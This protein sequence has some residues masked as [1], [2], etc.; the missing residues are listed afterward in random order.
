MILEMLKKIYMM[1]PPSLKNFITSL[2]GFKLYKERYNEYYNMCFEHYSKQ[3]YENYEKE[4]ELQFK[5][6][7]LFIQKA[8][9]DSSFYNDLYANINLN[10][11]KSMEDIKLL[12]IVTKESLRKNID[13][14]RTIKKSEGVVSFT[15]GTTGTSLEVVFTKQDF[16]ERMAYLDAFKYK[17][18]INSG[19]K[20]ATFS[21][22]EIV[23]SK[24]VKKGVYWCYNYIYKQRMYSTFH[25]KDETIPSYLSDLNNFKPVIINGFVSAIY[26]I[27]KYIN[28]NGVA[29][30][31]TPQAIFTTSEA[32]LPHHK[33]VIEKAFKAKVYN[34]YASAEGAPFITECVAGSLHYNLDTGVIE[35]QDDNSILV[36]S[37]TTHGTPLIRYQIG[38][39]IYLS[40][41]RS[42]CKCGSTHPIVDRIGGR[43]V[44]FLYSTDGAKV[45][46]SHLAD[47][48][49]GIPS[50]VKKIQFVQDNINEINI[51]ISVDEKLY[52][53]KDN[54]KIIKSML[55]R[56]GEKTKFEII[57]V[58]SIALEKSGK[59]SLIKNNMKKKHK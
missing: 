26:L 19:D 44:D 52:T 33:C 48:I 31:F 51:F 1:L 9:K 58:D 16:Q 29:L 49:K 42:K 47:V 23:S 56:F 2:Y 54:N 18:G 22:R 20:K 40:E 25:I 46:L 15:G 45:S 50:S 10:L 38:D 35:V 59:Y 4:K 17:L 24:D 13:K 37:F 57:K 8:K 11:I 53:P 3:N 55:V 5:K 34:Q 12:P 6:F 39:S 14:V 28:D 43:S 32:L 7:I 21:G 27:A 41:G 30:F 36:T